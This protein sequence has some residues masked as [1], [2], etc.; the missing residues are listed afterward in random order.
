[1]VNNLYHRS[2]LCIVLSGPVTLVSR[3]RETPAPLGI[4]SAPA[5]TVTETWNIQFY[6]VIK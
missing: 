5:I 4:H 6:N 3:T 1:M 2:F